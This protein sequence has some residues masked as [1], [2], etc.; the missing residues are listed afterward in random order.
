[1]LLHASTPKKQMLGAGR[2]SK[3]NKHDSVMRCD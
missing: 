3:E 1:M 2:A